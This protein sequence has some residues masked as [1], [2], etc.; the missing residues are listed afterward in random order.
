[1]KKTK[2]STFLLL[3]LFLN[4]A[5]FQLNA[6]TITVTGKVTQGDITI[7]LEGVIVNVDGTS[8]KAVSGKDGMYSIIAKPTDRLI[9][10]HISMN[11][12]EMAIGGKKV[13]NVTM[14]PLEKFMDEV[15]SIGY[16]SVNKKD[17]MGAISSISRRSLKDIPISSVEQALT[18]RLAGVQVTTSE[19]TPDAEV[20]IKVRGG[21]SITQDN[22]PIYIVDGIQME[23]GL[24][25]LAI[26]DIESIDVLKDASSTAIYGA[27]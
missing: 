20:K 11:T 17:V 15:V 14:E 23:E 22:S 27:R 18:G 25:G 10:T 19:G 9:F 6:Q 21:N 12:L 3:Y 13:L 4:M 8:I 5:G 24:K 26:Q 1:M 2:T 7:P 16:A